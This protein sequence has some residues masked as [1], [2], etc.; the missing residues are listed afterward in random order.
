MKSESIFKKE[1]EEKKPIKVKGKKSKPIKVK[2]L[3][4]PKISEV[5]RER[6]RIAAERN[7]NVKTK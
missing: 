6:A 1:T 5:A 7:F 4:E 3:H 2:V